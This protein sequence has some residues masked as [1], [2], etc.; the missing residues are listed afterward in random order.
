MVTN[1]RNETLKL[2]LFY[3]QNQENLLPIDHNIY[4]NRDNIWLRV[5]LAD[6]NDRLAI[7]QCHH[8]NMSTDYA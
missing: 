4:P 2:F 8:F 6:K 1:V 7:R 3:F 5:R